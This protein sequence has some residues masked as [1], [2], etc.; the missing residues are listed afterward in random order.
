VVLDGGERFRSKSTVSDD[1]KR[2]TLSLTQYLYLYRIETDPD[3]SIDTLRFFLTQKEG[4]KK[5]QEVWKADL[6]R[7]QERREKRV[8]C[9]MFL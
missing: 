9:F 5:K 2:S 1:R 8:S 4:E 3:T 7:N 6:K